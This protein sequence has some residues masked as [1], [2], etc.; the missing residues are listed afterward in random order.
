LSSRFAGQKK[1]KIEQTALMNKPNVRTGIKH[2]WLAAFTLIELLVVI[3]IIAILAAMLLPALSKAKSRAIV[4]QCAGNLKQWGLA[5]NMYAGDFQ[6]SFPDLT[7]AAGAGARDLSW[8]PYSF[9][10]DFYPNYLYRNHV[11]S[12]GHERSQNDV[13]YCPDDLWHRYEEQQPDYTSNLVGYFYLPGRDDAGAIGIGGTYNTTVGRLGQWCYRKKLGGP[14]RLAP[15]MSDHIQRWNNS[16]TQ[17]GV[18][19]GCHRGDGNVP[20]GANFLYEDGHVAWAKFNPANPATT[21]N[22]GIF[23]GSWALYFHPMDIG[24]GPW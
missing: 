7:G 21:I 16:W 12:A 4:I 2:R 13:L 15:I 8:M 24:G 18:Q 3:A 14:Y 20:F 11:G 6:N 9:N 23:G 5:V 17:N 1:L 22:V 10:T 19:L